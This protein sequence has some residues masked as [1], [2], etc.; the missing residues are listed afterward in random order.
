MIVG[1]GLILL[2]SF[3]ST[4]PS[5]KIITKVF[6]GISTVMLHCID[7]ILTVTRSRD[8][9]TASLL[10]TLQSLCVSDLYLHHSSACATVY[11]VSKALQ[12]DLSDAAFKVKFDKLQGL[13]PDVIT[14]AAHILSGYSAPTT[15]A[16]I[17][18]MLDTL[19]SDTSSPG[20]W[21]PV[22]GRLNDVMLNFLA[23][24][25][26]VGN[27]ATRAKCKLLPKRISDVSLAAIDATTTMSRAVDLDATTA[28]VREL[29]DIISRWEEN[30]DWDITRHSVLFFLASNATF[31]EFSGNELY[32]DL[33][34]AFLRMRDHFFVDVRL[35]QSLIGL[36]Q[37]LVTL[38]ATFLRDLPL[39]D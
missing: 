3:V 23:H 28:R 37:A 13:S 2:D 9:E 1:L 32:H 29:L 18:T 31:E 36:Y 12:N 33:Y 15:A 4:C 35:H 34:D 6:I 24:W 20:K 17:V 21:N 19:R 22:F 26:S 11:H 16:Q 7:S 25:K 30:D 14:R 5:D 39:D 27:H 8:K 38:N 10:R